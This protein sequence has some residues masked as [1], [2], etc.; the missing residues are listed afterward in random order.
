MGNVQDLFLSAPLTTRTHFTFF[1]IFATQVLF[2]DIHVLLSHGQK[3]KKVCLKCFVLKRR[4]LSLSQSL[5][6]G[7]YLAQK[8][9]NNCFGVTRQGAVCRIDT[10]PKRS[11]R[12]KSEGAWLD[13]RRKSASSMAAASARLAFVLGS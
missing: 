3:R 8:V 11:Q 12:D 13:R 7:F 6:V 2:Q 4:I 10:G 1:A 5:R 9:W